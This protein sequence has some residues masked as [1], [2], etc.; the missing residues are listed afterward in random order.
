MSVRILGFGAVSSL[1]AVLSACG[2]GSSSTPITQ[3]TLASVAIGPTNP[4]VG[5]GAVHQLTAT[6]IYSDSS[7]SNVTTSAIWSS[8]DTSKATIHATGSTAGLATGVAT[9]SSTITATF[10]GMSGKATLTVAPPTS[11][12]VSPVN[13][14]VAIGATQQLTATASYSDGS[15]SNV[16]TFATWSSS[17]TSKATIPA[18]GSNAGLATGVAAGTSTITATLSGTSGGTTLTAKTEAPTN[19]AINPLNPSIAVGASQPFTATATYPDGST[20]VATHLATWVS[21]D[22]TR[23]TINTT[24][25]ATAV[26]AKSPS[27]NI[28]ATFGG[29]TALTVLN[30]TSTAAQTGLE[31]SEVN[32]SLAPGATL[33]FIAVADY[34]DGSSQTVTNAASWSSSDAT[35]ATVET[36]TAANPGLIQGVASGATTI[37]A[38]FNGFQASTGVTVASNAVAIPLMDMNTTQNYLGFEGGLYQGSSKTPPAAHDAAG[39]A[40]ASAIQP[41]D[42][43]GNPSS[44]GA[45]VFLGIGMSNA[46]IEFSEFVNAAVADAKINHSTLAIE[47]GAHGAVTACPWT[48]A[49]GSPATLCGVSPQ[50]VPG[51]N[52]YDRVRDTVLA[53]AIGA[54]SAPANCTGPPP[55][56][57]CLTE[58]QV[59]VIWMK[60]A[61]PDPGLNGFRAVSSTTNCASELPKPT[62]EACIYEQQMGNIVRA[63]KFR[64]PN[65]KQ[66]FLSTRIYAGY[67]PKPLNPEP[68]AY[69]YGFSGKWLIQ[70]QID[71]IRNNGTIID[72]VAGDLNYVS[73]SAA[74]TAWGPYLW[75][76]GTSPRSD[77]LIWCNGQSGAPCNGEL[78]FEPDGTHPSSNNPG[79]D[80]ATKVLNELM[81]F[82]KTSAY[83]TSWFC[84]TGT[85]CP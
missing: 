61:N 13:P 83:T 32:P 11:I 23:A 69:E 75:A 28:Q 19:L 10:S 60:N 7:A 56:V 12:S 49:N 59:Q 57:P 4:S 22:P 42:Q 48:L 43:N 14:S 85:A 21:S 53:T 44:N 54:P 35:K 9:G 58:A 1:L 78:D 65:L 64:Y 36:G 5:A 33:Q 81:T 37:T 76:N 34:A 51:E 62:T 63:A 52:Q 84:K 31:L 41:L 77:G 2:G 27:P 50:S 16:T 70:A 45:V 29:L 73:G 68:Y 18:T 67:A 71:Q 82:F 8:S 6:A 17:D 3:K 15:T 25:V 39:K 46:T 80:G 74:W 66:I 24:G 30:I 38:T 55:A 40:A 26:S 79:H 72:P 47:N 20:E